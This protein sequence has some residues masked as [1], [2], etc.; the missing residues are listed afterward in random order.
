MQ[1]R[2]LLKEEGEHSKTTNEGLIRKIQ[3]LEEEL[4]SAEQNVEETVEKCVLGSL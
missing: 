1:S 4:D 2:R 3:L